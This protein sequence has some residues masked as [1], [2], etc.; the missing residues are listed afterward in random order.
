MMSFITSL[1]FAENSVSVDKH[2][3]SLSFYL[4]ALL[5][6]KKVEFEKLGLFL[7]LYMV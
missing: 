2:F 7:L 1:S 5:F 3:F 6:P 4:F